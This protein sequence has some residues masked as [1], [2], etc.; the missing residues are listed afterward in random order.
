MGAYI[1]AMDARCRAE[2]LYKHPKTGQKIRVRRPSSTCI[3][4]DCRG[5][6]WRGDWPRKRGADGFSLG[7]GGT[8]DIE[9]G[10][11]PISDSMGLDLDYYVACLI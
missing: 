9:D 6:R 10:G 3:G 11:G 5:R 2:S 7:A 4:W 1:D 8:S